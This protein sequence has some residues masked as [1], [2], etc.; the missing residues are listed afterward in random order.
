MIFRLWKE[1]T[2]GLIVALCCTSCALNTPS[3][4]SRQALA[5][6]DLGEAYMNSGDYTSALRE[7]HNAE[8]LNPSDPLIHND[9]GLTYMAKQS[10]DK[11]IFHFEKAVSLNAEY[12]P[13]RNNLGTAYLAAGRWDDAISQLKTVTDDLLYAGTYK[14]LTNLGWAY[15]NKKE[16]ETA[17]GCYK[18]A[19][20]SNPRFIIAMRG[21]AQSYKAMGRH[22]EALSTI[23]DAINITPRFPPLYKDM[24]EIQIAAGDT[25]AAVETY[26]KAIALFPNTSFAEDAQRAAGE[27]LLKQN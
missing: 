12:A 22:G 11:A 21:L 20:E 19:L 10:L 3:D 7:L 4:R 1:M 27:L 16:Y 13:A 15:Y 6:R 24:A 8:S 5:A 9:L 25:K 14:P 26:K 2:M 18:K 17:V 23:T